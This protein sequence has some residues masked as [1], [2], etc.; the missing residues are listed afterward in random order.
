[1]TTFARHTKYLG[2]AIN[3]AKNN[4]YNWHLGSV[5]AKGNK[6]I[7]AKPNRYRNDPLVAPHNASIHAEVA[8]IKGGER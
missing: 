8:V 2:M 6:F 1:M 3:V 7:G 4:D 5:L